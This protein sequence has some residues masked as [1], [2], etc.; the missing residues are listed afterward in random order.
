MDRA[1]KKLASALDGLRSGVHLHK[2]EL[3][4]LDERVTAEHVCLATVREWLRILG[5]P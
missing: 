1:K 4:E 2:S 3:L 5:Y